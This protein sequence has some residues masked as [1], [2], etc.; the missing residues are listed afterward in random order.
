MYET[1]IPIPT[2]YPEHHDRT[3]KMTSCGEESVSVRRGPSIIG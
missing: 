3:A 2:I 1:L